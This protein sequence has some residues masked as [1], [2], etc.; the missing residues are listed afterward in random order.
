MHDIQNHCTCRDE[1]SVIRNHH[2]DSSRLNAMTRSR[3][4]DHRRIIWYRQHIKANKQN[5][6]QH[7]TLPAT[8]KTKNNKQNK[9][10]NK[11]NKQTKI[12]I[13]KMQLCW[14]GAE[15]HCVW[16][17]IT[18]SADF[19]HLNTYWFCSGD[20]YAEVPGKKSGAFYI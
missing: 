13:K 6:K 18:I 11:K 7:R 5:T 9:Q 10:I 19:V 8:N 4:W 1:K 15:R 14:L 16:S 20:L 17:S 3:T 2:H 12:K